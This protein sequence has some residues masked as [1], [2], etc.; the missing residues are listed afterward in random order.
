MDG[1]LAMIARNG[2]NFASDAARFKNIPC[3]LVTVANW[4]VMLP[5]DDDNAPRSRISCHA[6]V[7]QVS[8]KVDLNDPAQLLLLHQVGQQGGDRTEISADD[9]V[10]LEKGASRCVYVCQEGILAL[11]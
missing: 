1:H 2:T 6:S 9:G 11:Q 4:L 10:L 5:D 3:A 7:A 8:T